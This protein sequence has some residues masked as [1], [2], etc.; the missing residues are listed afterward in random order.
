LRTTS[1]HLETVFTN[2]SFESNF[3][4]RLLEHL[5]PDKVDPDFVPVHGVSA[6]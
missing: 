1:N 3:V 6:T 4:L 2:S 5:E